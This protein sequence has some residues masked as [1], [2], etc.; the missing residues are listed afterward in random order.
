MPIMIQRLKPFTTAHMFG[1]DSQTPDI[2]APF[3]AI[4]QSLV[5][6][7]F[8]PSLAI[9]FSILPAQTFLESYVLILFS[10]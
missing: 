2:F 3:A 4:F 6:P 8:S 9:W 1:F 7:L 10:V 5:E